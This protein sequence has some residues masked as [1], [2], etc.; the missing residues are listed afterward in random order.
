[1]KQKKNPFEKILKELLDK[2]V[3]PFDFKYK[4]TEEEKMKLEILKFIC[5]EKGQLSIINLYTNNYKKILIDSAIQFLQKLCLF[6]LKDLISSYEPE[7]YQELKETNLFRIYLK[8]TKNELI[9]FFLLVGFYSYINLRKNNI[10]DIKKFQSNDYFEKMINLY[11]NLKNILLPQIINYYKKNIISQRNKKKEKSE[12]LYAHEDTSL[13][14][15]DFLFIFESYSCYHE[16]YVKNDL[17]FLVDSIFS[18]FT[19]NCNYLYLKERNEYIIVNALIERMFELIYATIKDGYY[20]NEEIQS[21]I[22]ALYNTMKEYLGFSNEISYISFVLSYC[23]KYKEEKI[24]GKLFTVCTFFKGL[25]KHN[26]QTTFNKIDIP[27]GDQFYSN[28]EKYYEIFFGE[29]CEEKF[30][31]VNNSSNNENKDKDKEKEEH[32]LNDK[33]N[34]NNSTKEKDNNKNEINESLMM[35]KEEKNDNNIIININKDNKCANESSIVEKN[36]LKYK[37]EEENNISL[38]ERIK[39]LENS[40]QESKKNFVECEENFNQKLKQALKEAEENFNKKLKQVLKESEEKSNKK[41]KESEEKFKQFKKQTSINN[42]KFIEKI[43]NLNEEI[44]KLNSSM[45]QIKFRDISKEIIK[46]YIQENNTKEVLSLP[47]KKEKAYYITKNYLKGKEKKYFELIVKKYYL[48][49]E[50]SHF[51]GLIRDYIKSD[52]NS[53]NEIKKMIVKEYLLNILEIDKKENYEKEKNF[54]VNLFGLKH[55]ISF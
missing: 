53:N 28:V 5:Y 27:N 19:E 17:Y 54:I 3:I 46:N 36:D 42:I 8:L 35:K 13:T 52:I 34:D 26:F 22:D 9:P 50:Q 12:Y 47:N 23:E 33:I 6:E 44:N 1:M 25:N 37:E 18:A 40:I 45:K 20:D 7:N 55:I 14:H 30:L 41:L 39:E 21:L 48:S 2:S 4:F 16:L 49:N 11:I 10:E 43:S 15:E 24:D 38:L 31:D 29:K 32:N 51:S